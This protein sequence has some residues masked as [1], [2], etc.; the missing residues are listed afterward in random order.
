MEYQ[1]K[2]DRN[3][4]NSTLGDFVGKIIQ[5]LENEY[6]PNE[7]TNL[8]LD[9]KWTI[10]TMIEGEYHKNNC[11]SNITSKIIDYL[12]TNRKFNEF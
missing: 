12:R 10:R 6:D 8:T 9:E 4:M 7:F 1:N 5:Y 2:T 3:N 11:V